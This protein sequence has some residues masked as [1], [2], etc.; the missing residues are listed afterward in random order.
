[1]PEYASFGI[2][3]DQSTF[4]SSKIHVD[5]AE[6]EEVEEGDW[7]Y[8]DDGDDDM[9]LDSEPQCFNVAH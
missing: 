6:G 9:V 8:E 4:Y 5:A 7:T 1:M 2:G 3:P